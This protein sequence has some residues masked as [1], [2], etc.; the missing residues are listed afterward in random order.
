MYRP[1][2]VGYLLIVG[3]LPTSAQSDADFVRRYCAG[4]P[5]LRMP[6][7]T[8]ADCIGPTHAKEIEF[9]EYWHT[10]LGQSLHYAYWTREIAAQPKAY[11]ELSKKIDSL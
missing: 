3:T 4:H 1:A 2:I 6:D 10:A 11:P 5:Q 7:K 8:E 9:S